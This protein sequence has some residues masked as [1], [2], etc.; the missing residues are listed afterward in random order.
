[1]DLSMQNSG[2]DGNWFVNSMPCPLYLRER[3]VV[4]IAEEAE[5]F[6]S[7]EWAVPQGISGQTYQTLA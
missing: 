1:M 3:D 7:I 6:R 5:L 2:L 4:P